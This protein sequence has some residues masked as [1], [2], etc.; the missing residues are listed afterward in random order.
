MNKTSTK[1]PRGAIPVLAILA[2]LCLA[3]ALVMAMYVFSMIFTLTGKLITGFFPLLLGVVGLV[4]GIKSIRLA[5]TRSKALTAFGK[6][7]KAL[8]DLTRKEV[9][10]AFVE[11]K[12]KLV[13]IL[14]SARTL[15]RGD[16]HSGAWHRALEA[17]EEALN[18][19]DDFD[20]RVA[21]NT[22]A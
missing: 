12:D 3:A 6:L 9:P 10:A 17:A 15:V 21:A 11:E 7:E 4:M 2:V 20:E 16:L 13:K 14:E 18:A 22:P 1:A 5:I 8:A 19:L